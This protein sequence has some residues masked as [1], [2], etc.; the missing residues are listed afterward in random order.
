ML[1][2]SLSEV[3]TAMASYL[4]HRIFFISTYVRPSFAVIHRVQS[5]LETPHGENRTCAPSPAYADVIP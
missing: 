1:S 3:F 5:D 4:L 2:V